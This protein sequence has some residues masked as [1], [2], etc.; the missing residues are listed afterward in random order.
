MHYIAHLL[1]A[2]H[3]REDLFH[4]PFTAEQVRAFGRGVVPEGEL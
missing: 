3:A 2:F 1:R 4:P